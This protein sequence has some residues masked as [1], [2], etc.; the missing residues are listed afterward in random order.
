MNHEQI[1]KVNRLI[2]RESENRLLRSALEQLKEVYPD[3]K[4]KDITLEHKHASPFDG[5]ITLQ[6]KN[7]T[8]HCLL[9]IKNRPRPENISHLIVLK[10]SD[11]KAEATPLLLV[12][13]YLNPAL[14]ARLKEAGINY[15]D[16]VGNLFLKSEPSL[17][18]YVEG[19][20]PSQPASGFKTR[21]FQPSGL[22]L[23]FGLL[24]NPQ[25]VNY[26]YRQLVK[27]NG[28]ALG[29]VGWVMRDLREQRFLE[30][31]GKT[32]SRLVR[33]KDLVDQWVQAYAQTLRPKILVGEFGNL[34]PHL[35]D[36]VSAIEH[37]ADPTMK[38]ALSGGFA[39]DELL[40]HYQGQHLTFYVS[41][42]WSST[43]PRDLP[44]VPQPGGDITVLRGFSPLVFKGIQ[45]QTEHPTAHPLLVYAEL[46]YQGT[47]R[48]LE[49][50]R[51]LYVEFLEESLV[52]K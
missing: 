14:T 16:T 33:I 31:T 44:L 8:F 51:M 52:S 21:L 6:T 23:L 3:L 18:L 9:E 32:E 13:D 45:K 42:W 28:V 47:D 5:E 25:S 22:T 46:L 24:T 29:T 20:R 38:W 35:Q 11:P 43:T 26:P 1:K 19:K 2:G 49:T 7:T 40:H 17:H 34:A 50:A 36:V 4:P 37:Y 12:A 27:E 39:A 41:D 48:S 30:P 10:N 15:I